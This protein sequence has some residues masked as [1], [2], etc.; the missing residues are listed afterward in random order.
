MISVLHF[1]SWRSPINSKYYY[2]WTIKIYTWFL[3]RCLHTL[4]PWLLYM[5][6][7]ILSVAWYCV[8]GVGCWVLGVEYSYFGILVQ[9]W[10]DNVETMSIPWQVCLWSKSLVSLTFTGLRGRR[11]AALLSPRNETPSQQYENGPLTY[12]GVTTGVVR[13]YYNTSPP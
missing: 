7:C 8:R 3:Y 12:V 6:L 10:G 9:L 2:T 11:E 5:A 1:V 4:A 13:A